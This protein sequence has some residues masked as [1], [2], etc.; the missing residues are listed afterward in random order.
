[1]LGP[2]F[3]LILAI[4]SICINSRVSTHIALKFPFFNVNC[5]SLKR[6]KFTVL[7]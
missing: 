6:D 5:P 3:G 1:M 7:T 2:R 4:P